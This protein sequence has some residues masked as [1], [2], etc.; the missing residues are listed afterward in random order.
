M[1]TFL[2]FDTWL[3]IKVWGVT[4][5]TFLFGAANL[6]MMMRHGLNLGL[7]ETEKSK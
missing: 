7:E 3:T 5:A 2:S 1:R 4:V 6:P